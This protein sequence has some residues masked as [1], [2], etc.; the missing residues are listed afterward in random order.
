MCPHL[1]TVYQLR[2]MD[3]RFLLERAARERAVRIALA[4]PT[5]RSDRR[6]WRWAL[7]FP[8]IAPYRL[9]RLSRAWLIEAVGVSRP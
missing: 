8:R 4:D 9:G 2:E 5:G 1:E 3:R 6:G 7:R